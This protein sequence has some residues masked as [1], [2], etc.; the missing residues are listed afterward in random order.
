MI[1]PSF[2][3]LFELLEFVDGFTSMDSRLLPN[4]KDLSELIIK[5]SRKKVHPSS[6]SKLF[7]DSDVSDFVRGHACQDIQQ[8]AI[9]SPAGE[10]E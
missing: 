10:V 4:E 1:D 8:T 6:S 7:F 9:P 5:M 2:I 3:F